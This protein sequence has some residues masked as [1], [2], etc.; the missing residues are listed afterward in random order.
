MG[1]ILSNKMI[2]DSYIPLYYVVLSLLHTV[3]PNLLKEL[4]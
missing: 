2:N 3:G 1:S 4:F